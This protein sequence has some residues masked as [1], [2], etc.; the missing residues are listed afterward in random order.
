MNFPLKWKPEFIFN[1]KHQLIRE[2]NC[3]LNEE[4]TCY[5]IMITLF[6]EMGKFEMN[7][8]FGEYNFSH[9]SDD[10]TSIRRS[11]FD[12][13]ANS[14]RVAMKDIPFFFVSLSP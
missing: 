9:R 3:N 11:A 14:N 8:N 12:V 5:E 2:I 13:V 6:S 4:L 10:I 7:S 1:I